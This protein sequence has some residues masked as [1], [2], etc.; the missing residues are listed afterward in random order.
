MKNRHITVAARQQTSACTSSVACGITTPTPID[1]T[2]NPKQRQ[3]QCKDKH[4]QQ[5]TENHNMRMSTRLSDDATRCAG[6][7]RMVGI[8]RR[9]S[10][11]TGRATTLMH[12]GHHKRS[13][14]D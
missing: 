10:A 5:P 4:N 8:E 7:G 9:S 2:P 1:T 6:K 14:A 12:G 13:G 11:G 3:Q